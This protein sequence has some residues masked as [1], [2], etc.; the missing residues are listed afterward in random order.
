MQY[1]KLGISNL[2]VSAIC[3][4]T[5]EFGQSDEWGSGNIA[6]Y[7]Q[8][9][10]SAIDAGI[11]FIDT[12]ELYGKSEEILGELLKGRRDKVVLATKIGGYQWDYNTMRS[13]LEQ[14]LKRLQTDYVDVYFVHWPKIKGIDHGN[15][16]SNME[17]EDYERI[18]YSMDRLK[19]EGLIRTAGVSNFRL[20]HLMKFSDEIF[21]V[22]VTDQIPYALLWRAYDDSETLDFCK[23]RGLTYLTYSSLAVG[24]LSGQYRKGSALAPAQ[25]ANILFNEPVLSRA[26]KVVDVVR[27][28]AKEVDASPAQVA[29][30]WVVDREM[31]ASALV[32]TRNVKN[33]KQN[34]E[35]V[36]LHLTR[37]QTKRLDEAS[38]EFWS[39]IPSDLEMWTWDNTKANLDRIGVSS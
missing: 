34:A 15:C 5:W 12:A 33:M 23:S 21:K 27:G 20:H 8:V 25:R 22:V 4:G 39:S 37:E 6:D 18:A 13:R 10:D 3:L 11:N 38:Q 14:S 1:K 24:L 17:D 29:L 7:K 26:L 32:A 16:L 19:N 35:S 9:I 31:T 30:K 2:K 36:K 28:V